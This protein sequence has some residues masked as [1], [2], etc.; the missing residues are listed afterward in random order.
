MN[1]PIAKPTAVRDGDVAVTDIEVDGREAVERSVNRTHAGR[2]A[3]LSRGKRDMAALRDAP[4]T[5]AG[6]LF[7]TQIIQHH[8]GAIPMALSEIGEGRFPAAQT[9]AQRI[10][11][12]QKREIATMQ[13]ML[14]S[15]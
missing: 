8:G 1:G 10:L 13:E 2:P 14:E 12:T 7:L 3:S 15:I 11:S 4:G 5:A 6:R 9:M